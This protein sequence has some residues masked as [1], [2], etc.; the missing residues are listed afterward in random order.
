M[1]GHGAVTL[2]LK[3]P[4]LYRSV[5]A[6]APVCN[7][8]NVPWGKKAFGNYLASESEWPEHD[9]TELVKAHRS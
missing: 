1:G 6:F 3:H 2:A 9:A 4:D 5:S 8:S 7:P